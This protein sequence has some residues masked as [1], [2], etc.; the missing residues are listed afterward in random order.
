MHA[1]IECMCPVAQHK[2]KSR[3]IR[4]QGLGLVLLG[5]GMRW[6][7]AVAIQFRVLRIIIYRAIILVHVYRETMH[8]K[9]KQRSCHQHVASQ[10]QIAETGT[11]VILY[12]W[13]CDMTKVD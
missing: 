8:V 7:E 6:N 5:C 9:D 10:R 13:K 11:Y 12:L 2:Y 4:I 1:D 3:H